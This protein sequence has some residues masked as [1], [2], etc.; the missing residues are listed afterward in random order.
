[1]VRTFCDNALGK[2]EPRVAVFALWIRFYM[3]HLTVL[4]RLLWVR[5]APPSLIGSLPFF[6]SSKVKKEHSKASSRAISALG[7]QEL[8]HSL[9]FCFLSCPSCIWCMHLLEG[10]M[11]RCLSLI[12]LHFYFWG[13]GLLLSLRLTNSFRNLPVFPSFPRATMPS[14]S[15]HLITELSL[16]SSGVPMSSFL[17]LCL[18]LQNL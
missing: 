14:Y 2:C 11:F 6:W 15:S 5:G 8:A 9:L 4:M 18:H 7:W 12:T 16:Y 1:M 10:C 13:Q 3:W 17:N